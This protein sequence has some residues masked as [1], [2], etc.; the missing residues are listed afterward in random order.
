MSSPSPSPN[1]SDPER[2]VFVAHQLC[3]PHLRSLVEDTVQAFDESWLC[4]PVEGEVFES[5]KACLARLQGFALSKGFAVVTT[6]SR[7]GRFRF[8]CIHHGKESKNWRKFK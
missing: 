4:A 7:A 6:N 2:P 8:G 5:G 1:L 3:P